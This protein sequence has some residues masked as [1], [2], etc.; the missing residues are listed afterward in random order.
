M[1]YQA[2]LGKTNSLIEYRELCR[3]VLSSLDNILD[4]NA[5]PM[6]KDWSYSELY[7]TSDKLQ[8][9]LNQTN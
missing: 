4:P 3:Q 7:D 8:I 1:N 6:G 9:F 5:I 2:V